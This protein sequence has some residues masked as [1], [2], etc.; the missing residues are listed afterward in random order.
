MPS[1]P[2]LVLFDNVFDRI[3]QYPLATVTSNGGVI[4]GR[5]VKAIG[6]Y[7][8]ERTYYQLSAATANVGPI[9]DLGAGITAAVD[10]IFIDRG[11]NLWGKT[12]RFDGSDDGAIWGSSDIGARVVPALVG[13][14]FVPGGD[15][16]VGWAVTEE[17]A[18][19]ALSANIVARRWWRLYVVE[20]TQTLL[21]G[22]IAGKRTQ[23]DS[24]S[25]T[26]DDDAGG[27]KRS[28]D[29]SDAGYTAGS[30]VYSYRNLM[31]DLAVI[32]A[33]EYDTKIRLLRRALFEKNIA[34]FVVMNYGRWPERGWLYQL[35]ADRWNFPTNGVHRAGTIPLR[36]LYPIIR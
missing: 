2:P 18:L 32:G 26:L 12:V 15:P 22:L 25:R 33:T 19:Y 27:R 28:T 9:V 20:A 4:T 17:G 31:L 3:N 35:D 34:A 11:H 30:R 5:E 14:N 21:T 1:Q 23:L 13:G 16:T 24:Y 6:D 10:T 29:E 36:E 7:R 8:R